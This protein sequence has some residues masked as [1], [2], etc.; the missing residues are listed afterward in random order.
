MKMAESPYYFF[1]GGEYRGEAPAFYDLNQ[2][3]W[4]SVLEANWKT[5]QEEMLAELDPDNLP[6]PNYNPNLVSDAKV[7]RNICFYNYMWQKKEVCKRY[8]KTHALLKQIPNL[9]YAALNMLEPNSEI[10]RHQGDTNIT[11]RCHLGLLVPEGL[12]NCGMNINGIDIAWQ[13]GKFFAFSDAQWHSAWN[14]TSK[15][16][17]VFVIDV[18][19]DPYVSRKEYYCSKILAV[20]SFKVVSYKASFLNILPVF[21]IKFLHLMLSFV[22]FT[23]IKIQNHFNHATRSHQKKY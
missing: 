17:F 13:E 12:P 16:R 9:S 5:I 14:R 11:A 19:L 10:Y 7:W 18:I 6:I 21:I 23:F 3:E 8:P 20:L 1:L 22:W 15:Y 2:F 4:V